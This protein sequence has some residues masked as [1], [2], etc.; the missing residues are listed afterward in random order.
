M[1]RKIDIFITHIFIWQHGDFGDEKNEWN[2]S[3][4][5]GGWLYHNGRKNF[6]LLVQVILLDSM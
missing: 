6:V 4:L 1:Q 5:V 2:D 3:P